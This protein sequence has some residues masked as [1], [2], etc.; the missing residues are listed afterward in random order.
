[1]R[2]KADCVVPAGVTKHDR[3]YC[4]DFVITKKDHKIHYRRMSA[5]E[6]KICKS[7]SQLLNLMH[8]LNHPETGE[9]K[10]EGW[11]RLLLVDNIVMHVYYD[12]HVEM[13]ECLKDAFPRQQIFSTTHSGILIERHLN[14]ENDSDNELWI[15]LED[16]NG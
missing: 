10:M 1:M 5:G 13:I 12:R 2:Y 16:N 8:D 7:F 9:P 15:N 14:G 11:P 4:T 6:R 3:G